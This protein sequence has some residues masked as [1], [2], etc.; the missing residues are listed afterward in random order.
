MEFILKKIVIIIF[1]ILAI[2]QALKFWV[3][4]HMYLGQEYNILG[5]WFII[6]FTEN[7]GMAFG[8]EFGGKLGKLFLSIFRIIAIF[9]IAWYLYDL[10]KKKADGGLVICVS[11][12]FVGALGNI[13]DS[14]FYGM[15][16]SESSC[17]LAEFLPEEG[18]YAGLL[19][20]KVVDMFYFPVIEGHFPPWFPFWA[21]EQFIFFR[22]V[23]NIADS[24]ITVGVITIIIFQKRF[25]GVKETEKR[26]ENIV[27]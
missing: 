1:I 19:H 15:I 12:V 14:T 2:D 5:D 9:V 13:I 7:S 8:L 17:R 26:G 3:K 4:T 6:H 27:T 23:F 22:P 11:L 16:F 25:F 18:G 24:A 20:G 21:T 10:I